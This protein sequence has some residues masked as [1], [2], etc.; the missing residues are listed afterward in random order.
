MFAGV[1]FLIRASLFSGERPV[2][3]CPPKTQQERRRHGPKHPK[4]ENHPNSIFENRTVAVKRFPPLI[5]FIEALL[6]DSSVGAGLSPLPGAVPL[7]WGAEPEW[8]RRKGN[9]KPTLP[10]AFRMLRLFSPFAFKGNLSLLDICV[11][12]FFFSQGA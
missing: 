4:F 5:P 10:F 2:G 1:S 12:C 7:A 8:L 6:I 11:L 3:C 9:G